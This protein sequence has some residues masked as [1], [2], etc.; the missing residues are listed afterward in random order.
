MCMHHPQN[1][2]KTIGVMRHEMIIWTQMY[3][4]VYDSRLMSG[5]QDEFER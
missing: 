4:T 5:V 2:K 3:Q 1:Y